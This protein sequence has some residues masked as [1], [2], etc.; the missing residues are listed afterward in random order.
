MTNTLTVFLTGHGGIKHVV[1]ESGSGVYGGGQV[2][3]V[4]GT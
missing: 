1:D 4:C 3:Y 2:Q